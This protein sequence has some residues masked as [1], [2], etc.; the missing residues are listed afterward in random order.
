MSAEKHVFQAEIQQLL[1]I[2]IHSLYTD[3]EIFVRE[4]VSNA[5]DACER[6]RFVQASGEKEIFQP[7]TELSIAIKTD[8]KERT[9]TFTDTGIGLTHDELVQSLGTIAHSGTKT[10]LKQLAD[11]QRPDA[12]LIG[13]FG[14]GFYS[15]FMAARTVTV[16]TRSYRP[17]EQG[18]KWTSHGAGGYEMEPA[19]DLPRGTQ[20]ILTLKDDAGDFAKEYTV[21]DILK[22]YSNFV[23]F[24]IDLN[25]KKVNTVQA[26][27]ARNKSS[28]KEEEYSEFYK[29]LAHD[30]DA[31]LFRLHFTTDA[32][33]AIQALLFVPARNLESLGMVRLESEVHLYCRKVLIDARPKGLL[34]EWLRFL[35]GVVDSE[36]LP[37]NI[38]RE[39]MQDSTLIQKLNR[40]LTGRFLRFLEEQAEKKPD[41]YAKFYEQY[42]RFLKEGALNDFNHREALSKL[43]RWESSA[44][45]K[46]KTTTLAEYVGR[47][48]ADQKEIYYLL[49]RSREAA[50]ASSYYEVFRARKSEVLFLYDPWDEFVMERLDRFDDKP[51]VAAEKANVT[52]P[53]PKAADLKDLSAWMKERLGNVEEVRASQRL[54][55]SPA[56]VLERDKHMTLTMRQI[57]RSMGKGN[58]APQ[59]DLEIN[60]Q[61][62]MIAR[63]DELRKTDEALAGK[64]AEHIFDHA[65]MSA[66][67]LEDPR[68]MLQRMNELLEQ[69]LAGPKAT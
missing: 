49:S 61:H 10:F 52:L 48:P 43:L 46:G 20:I 29:Y 27:W 47:L 50:E 9:V 35:R 40:A 58:D 16:L 21:E 6:L 17:G 14:V 63:L 25:G 26:I 65:R 1:D 53:E 51:L 45:E 60:P 41:D 36:D 38:S 42:H 28:V 19:A 33:I 31:P 69:A 44:L 22:R 32:P 55:D 24:P 15:A 5:S 64:L 11:T 34:P 3:K 68:A 66:G 37:L 7:E 30:P 54:V 12:K 39:R 2:V 62:P 4:L 67:L 8:E 59:L 13:Q 18:W 56:V 57:L 23:Q